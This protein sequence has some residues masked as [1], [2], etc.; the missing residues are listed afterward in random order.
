[1]EAKVLA[2]KS[3]DGERERGERGSTD[4]RNE[5]GGWFFVDF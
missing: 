3:R 1:M 2:A 5:G 4:S